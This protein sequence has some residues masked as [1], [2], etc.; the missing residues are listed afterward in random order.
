MHHGQ[1]ALEKDS[2]GHNQHRGNL[3]LVVYLPSTTDT[4]PVIAPITPTIPE[5]SIRNRSL[6]AFRSVRIALRSSL[7]PER[8]R[9][10]FGP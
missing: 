4:S 1:S 9:M 7:I 10:D 3:S 2:R 5:V 6:L 8:V